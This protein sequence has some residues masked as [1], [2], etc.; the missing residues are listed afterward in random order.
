V[1]RIIYI[2]IAR[3]LA[4]GLP[5]LG[6]FLPKIKQFL[7]ER[8]VDLALPSGPVT[9]WIHAAS[10]G[11]YEMA[12]PL[13]EKLVTRYSKKEILITI[14]SPSGYTQA[15]KGPYADRI[16]YVPLD[17]L[18]NVRKFYN[19]YAP[20]KAI[21]IRYDF[22]YNLINEGLRSGTE[23]YLVN[24]RFTSNHFFFRWY[25]SPFL[26]LLRRFK[27]IFT[28]DA[29]SAV[30]LTSNKVPAEYIGDT[31]Y[32]RVNAVAVSAKENEEIIR[33][34]GDRKLLMLGSS[35]EAEESLLISLLRSKPKNFAV[36]VAPH[37]LKRT[38][39]IMQ[40]LVEFSP[41]KYTES[42]FSAADQVLILDTMGMLSSMYQ[43]ADF[44]LI[45]GG[46]RGALHNVLE[47]AVWGCDISFGPQI[48]KFP[49]AQELVKMELAYSITSSQVWVERINHLLK[50]KE[51]FTQVSRNIKAHCTSQLGATT[52]VLQ[53]IT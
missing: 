11:E 41:K 14:F 9:Y 38:D 52:K 21:L 46:F 47:P 18:S 28:S 17:T 31:R 29:L 40:E 44:A 35:W 34:K 15:I 7:K 39:S 51:Q 43:Y 26:S 24:G 25:G 12:V 50:D 13:I 6:L 8:E 4:A 16:M 30:L 42:N 49:E 36:I 33:F 32:D 1:Y 53:A 27:N 3:I 19:S 45:G 48:A 37:D 20:K 2:G 23:F 5:L 22:W 10:L